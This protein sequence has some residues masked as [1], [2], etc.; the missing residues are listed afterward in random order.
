[1]AGGF[2]DAHVKWSRNRRDERA[3][4]IACEIAS[5]EV[6]ARTGGAVRHD[7]KRWRIARMFQR[8]IRSWAGPCLHRP[9][10]QTG[11]REEALKEGEDRASCPAF[12]LNGGSIKGAA[13][14]LHRA[15][16]DRALTRAGSD[17]RHAQ[18][19]DHFAR[20]GV[21]AAPPGEGFGGLFRR[22]P[23]PSASVPAPA[24]PAT[25]RKGVRPLP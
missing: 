19:G 4:L 1:M 7:R 23:T 3:P 13:A 11:S 20:V 17:E 14:A 2:T 16:A 9:C 21:H 15:A 10:A 8:G 24:C 6:S 22:M 12:V 5:R 25:R 18:P